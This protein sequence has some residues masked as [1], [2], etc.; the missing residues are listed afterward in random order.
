MLNLT[1]E[2]LVEGLQPIRH[3]VIAHVAFEFLRSGLHGAL[4]E[5]PNA[6]VS[7]IANDL[8]LSPER[9]RA[10]LQFL[11]K[12]GYV[13]LNSGL[14]K[15]TRQGEQ[16]EKIA[17]WYFLL[18]GGYAKTFSQIGEVLRSP[19]TYASRDGASVGIGSCGISQHDALPMTRALLKKIDGEVRTIVDLGCG[20]GSYLLDLC[21]P[22]ST[23]RG[24]GFD[25]EPASV[26]L[27]NEAAEQRGIKDRVS[28]HVGSALELPDLSP[29]DGPYC[30]IT[31]F[32]LQELL[33][34]VGRTAIVD[35][36]RNTFRRHPSSHWI[37]V[38]VDNRWEDV[39]TMSTPLGLAY[40]NAYYLIHEVTEQRLESIS[41]WKGIFAEA[42]LVVSALEFPD[43]GYDHLKLKVGFLLRCTDAM[44]SRK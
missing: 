35:L 37:V 29:N 44:E 9:V 20:D 31:A 42:D 21:S 7:L 43:P 26:A 22:P 17:P 16:L 14:A 13:E 6:A 15:L 18:V 10:V 27:A 39:D 24:I 40:Y 32:V 23:L 38:E 12:E 25:P 4:R 11:A 33:E 3:F 36:L 5:C 8:G 34:Q 41:F 1:E 19:S 30:F 28:V 2:E